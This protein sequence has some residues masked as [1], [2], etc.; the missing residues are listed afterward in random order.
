M[1]LTDTFEFKNTF[2]LPDIS[3]ALVGVIFKHIDQEQK[4][5]LQK[6]I[7]Y[8]ICSAMISLISQCNVDIV[9]L[10]QQRCPCICFHKVTFI[11]IY[12]W[13]ATV[14]FWS[15]NFQWLPNFS[16]FIFLFFLQTI[17][18]GVTS[19]IDHYILNNVLSYLNF[20]IF[21][22]CFLVGVQ[23]FCSSH[24]SLLHLCILCYNYSLISK[25]PCK[26]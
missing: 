1:G 4:P 14:T 18:L 22:L 12:I 13:F 2:Y 19:W 11:V 5:F 15:F 9:N 7:W 8:Q 16:A 20:S 25:Q 10:F 21:L 26:G 3:T 17:S 23:L 24:F 6:L